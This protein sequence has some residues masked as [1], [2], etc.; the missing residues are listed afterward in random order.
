MRRLAVTAMLALAAS[1]ALAGC[2]SSPVELELERAADP[3]D[4]LPDWV[5]MPG[6]FETDS[7]RWLG[8]RGEI[9][10]FVA[11]TESPRADKDLCVLAVAEDP[12]WMA[13]CFGNRG[14]GTG[15]G[16]GIGSFAFNPAGWHDDEVPVGL[17]L[18]H[19]TLAVRE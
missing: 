12:L 16:Q 6:G 7:V 3:R 11:E 4:D 18:V 14:G 8:E 1:V 17:V 9:A 10:Y 19:P 5:A 13:T 15:R 2:S